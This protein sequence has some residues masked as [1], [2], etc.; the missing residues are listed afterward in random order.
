MISVDF[1]SDLM[2]VLHSLAETGVCLD[3]LFSILLL[4]C[5]PQYIIARGSGYFFSI[6]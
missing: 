6:L 5:L 4:E 1:F 2:S 3:I